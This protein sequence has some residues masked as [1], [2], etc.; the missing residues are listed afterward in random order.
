MCV[1]FLEK[2]DKYKDVKHQNDVWHGGKSLAKKDQCS[3]FVYSINVKIDHNIRSLN[4]I[5]SFLPN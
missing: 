4:I 3:K 1:H 5:G 2:A